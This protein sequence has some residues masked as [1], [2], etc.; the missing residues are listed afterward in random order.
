MPPPQAA[1]VS[2]YKRPPGA[3]EQPGRSMDEGGP[4]DSSDVTSR[5]LPE[6]AVRRR[7]S[8]SGTLK[9]VA[10]S[11]LGIRG[12][13][14]HEDDVARLNPLHVIAAGIVCA[15]LFVLLLVLIVRMVV[16]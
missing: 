1:P 16:G 15:V 8:F 5:P 2:Q 7:G 13:R 11:F 4:A 3:A 9:A 6:S 10:W 12:G 14:A